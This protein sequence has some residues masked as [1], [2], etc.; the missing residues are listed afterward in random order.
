MVSPNGIAQQLDRE[1]EEQKP[2]WDVVLFL[3]GSEK[4]GRALEGSLAA[5]RASWRRPKWH[6]VTAR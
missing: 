5:F 1:I 2:Q 3:D 4:E 6:I